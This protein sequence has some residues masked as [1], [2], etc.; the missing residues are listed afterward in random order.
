MGVPTHSVRDAGELR[1]LLAELGSRKIVLIDT[2]G[3]SQRDRHVAEQAAML[4]DAG[5][6]VRR[7]L[8]LNAA[9]QGDTLDEVAHAYRNGVGETWPAASSPSWTKPRAWARRWTRPSAT[10]C[11]SITCRSARRCLSTWSWRA[12]TR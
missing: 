1:R 9:S 2:T 7:L 8:V 5:K 10:V 6:T 3:I 4:C 11:R 12:P